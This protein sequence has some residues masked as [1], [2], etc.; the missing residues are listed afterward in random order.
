MPEKCAID[1]V[2]DA[3]PQ[4]SGSLDYNVVHSSYNTGFIYLDVLKS[5][6]SY[7]VVPPLA[8]FVMNRVKGDCFETLYLFP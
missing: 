6:D 1:K 8:G 5:D 3:G 7:V 4:L 2:I